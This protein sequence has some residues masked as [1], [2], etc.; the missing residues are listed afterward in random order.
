MKKIVSIGSLPVFVFSWCKDSQ[1]VLP[2][3][4][5]CDNTDYTYSDVKY[6]FENKWVGCHAY[7]GQAVVV[8]DFSSYQGFEAILNN[9]LSTFL[10]QIRCEMSDSHYN[11]PPNQKLSDDD[12]Q[13][14]ECWN[15]VGFPQ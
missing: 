6:I 1:T 5:L 13:K 8:G 12:L 11:M 4:E 14:S 2:N 7:V 10:S 3:S 15:E 9:D